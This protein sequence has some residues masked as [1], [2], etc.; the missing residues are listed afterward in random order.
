M[1][2]EGADCLNKSLK[3]GKLVKLAGITSIAKS[4]G[5]L[6]VT[7]KL[8]HQAMEEHRVVSRAVTDRQALGACLDFAR[9]HRLLVEPACGAAL[10]AVYSKLD[11]GLDKDNAPLIIVVCGGNMASLELF[12][13][14]KQQLGMKE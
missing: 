13:Q 6:A 12:E 1:E 9:D 4:L 3:E 2:T 5:A 7:Q 8:F 11:L 10:S 14:W